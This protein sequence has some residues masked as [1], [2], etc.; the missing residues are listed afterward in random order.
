MLAIF[1]VLP[2]SPDVR[3]IALLPLPTQ[4][5]PYAAQADP[6]NCNV[7]VGNISPEVEHEELRAI[8]AGYGPLVS[9][10]M[11]RKEGYGFAEFESHHDAVRAILGARVSYF[12]PAKPQA[13]KVQRG[14]LCMLQRPYAT[15]CM[16]AATAAR[17]GDVGAR[18]G[19]VALRRSCG[20]AVI[21]LACAF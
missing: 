6:M 4:P 14:A 17:D 5:L 12:R 10:R 1:N 9:M 20:P 7:Y 13:S 11:Y 21:S 16:H 8:I 19:W 2:H 15:D 3:A 18:A